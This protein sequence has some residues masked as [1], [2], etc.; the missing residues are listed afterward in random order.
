MMTRFTPM[1]KGA[2]W[3][4]ITPKRPG[5]GFRRPIPP[6]AHWFTLLLIL[7]SVLVAH[8]QKEAPSALDAQRKALTEAV[9]Q[10]DAAGVARIFTSDAKLMVTGFETVTGRKAIEKFWQGGLSGGMIQGVAF[11]PAD[12]T[13]EADGLLVE[14]GALTTLDADGKPRD[15]RRYLLVWKR[16]ESDWRIH[17]DMVNTES[18]PAPKADRV[19]FPKDYRSTFKMLG[20]PARTNMDSSLVMTA[21]GND[22]AASVTN[23]AQLPYPN[24]SILVMEFTKALIDAAGKPLLGANG[25]P[26]KGE[27]QHVD[28]MRRGADFGEAYGSNRAGHWE[29]AGYNLDGTYSTPPAKSASCA[30]CHQKAGGA[31]D[32]VFPLKSFPRE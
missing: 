6:R 13:G 10:R 24:G 21:Y 7:S 4:R 3:A 26:Q 23:A 1:E 30:Q 19:G 12:F 28:V 2:P 16:E 11:A 20:V 32:F 15:Q 9:A 18:A 8:A 14:T 27:V 25:Q 31:K 5:A 29:F 22:L 17:R